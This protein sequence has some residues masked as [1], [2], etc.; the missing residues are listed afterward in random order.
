MKRLFAP[1]LALGIGLAACGGSA[2]V[3]LPPTTFPTT[4][5]LPMI[6]IKDRVINL[7]AKSGFQYA[8][9]T[10]DVQFADTTG[11]FGK[12]KGE[13]LAKMETAFA[14]DNQALVPAFN[15]VVTT[16]VSQKTPQELATTDGKEGLRK[17]LIADFN[18]RLATGSAP[19]VY[20][21]FAD[22]V[23]Q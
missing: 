20:V 15:D 17:Q 9:M 21:N 5:P 13:A 22:F 14:S 12:A 4:Q 7:N 18:S 6:Q 3:V 23:M 1:I 11:Q 16:D 8:K 2:G 19:V 10:L